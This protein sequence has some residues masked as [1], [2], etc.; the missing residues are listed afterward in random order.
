MKFNYFY[1]KNHSIANNLDKLQVLRKIIEILPQLPHVEE[2]QRRESLLKSSLFSARIEGNKLKLE[3]L[4]ITALQKES[5]NIPKI[6]IA[7]ILKGLHWIYSLA[8]KKLSVAVILKLHQFVMANISEQSGY[9]R[10]EPSA[11][12]NQAGFAIY[13]PPPP[14]QVVN[15]IKNLVITVNSSKEKGPVNAALSHFTFEK[16]HPFLDGNGRVG[17]LLSTLILKNSGFDFRGLA[18]LEE[19]LEKKRQTYYDLLASNKKDITEFVDFFLEG[20]KVQA[21]KTLQRIKNVKAETP[22]DLLLPRRREILEIVRNHEYISF[23]FLKRRFLKIPDST[24]HYDIG[25]LLKSGFIKKL[26]TSRG[27][28]YTRSFSKF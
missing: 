28:V 26:G 13:L 10:K 15:L 27:V 25:K 8:P 4:S 1:K 5:H 20:L 17:R 9:F 12:F 16:I 14:T 3:D 23:N 2:F 6:E 24:L 21:D 11:I 19:Y 22:E 18:T 7:N